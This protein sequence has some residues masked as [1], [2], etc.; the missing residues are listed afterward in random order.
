M[1][2]SCMIPSGASQSV[3]SQSGASKSVVSQSG[4]SQSVISQ[5]GVVKYNIEPAETNR[6]QSAS[7]L[8][9]TY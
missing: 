5:S 8:D 7:H 9:N 6:K 2:Q 4:A 1:S 3:V